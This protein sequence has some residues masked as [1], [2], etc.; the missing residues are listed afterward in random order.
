MAVALNFALLVF[1]LTSV[2]KQSFAGSNSICYSSN[3]DVAISHIVTSLWVYKNQRG[4]YFGSNCH[5]GL[6]MLLLLA[7]DVKLCPGPSRRCF[8]CSKTI[9]KKQSSDSC[10]HCGK[11]CHIKCL[12][13][14]IE[15]G[16]ER[17]ACHNCLHRNNTTTTTAVHEKSC[18]LSTA[19]GPF[20]DIRNFLQTRGL[21]IFHQNING[22]ASKKNIVEALL[23]ET[24]QNIDILGLSE[25]H[26]NATIKDP[27]IEIEGYTFVRE[28]RA[29][30][31]GGGVGCYIRNG[32]AWQ[33]RKNLEK[34]SVEAIWLEVLL[35]SQAPSLFAISIGPLIRRDI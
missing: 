5:S 1:V 19:N 29:N 22:L 30:G 13:D 20:T 24:K 3:G 34:E 28:D 11:N 18:D 17:L 33:R 23:R 21:K 6:K 15:Y 25:T 31:R 35:K 7:G 10:F 14:R 26:L 27:V 2:K 9:R 12:V 32:I 8:T 16:H 4:I